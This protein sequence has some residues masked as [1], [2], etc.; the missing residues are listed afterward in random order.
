[1]I[2]VFVSV[3]GR[4]KR[5]END[6]GLRRY[7]AARQAAD[8]DR[9]RRRELR[10]TFF[11]RYVWRL[12]SRT[13]VQTGPAE[14]RLHRGL[15]CARRARG[16]KRAGGAWDGDVVSDDSDGERPPPR[17]QSTAEDP[18]RARLRKAAAAL[19]LS[20]APR[21]RLPCREAER[22]EVEAFILEALRAP[23]GDGRTLYVAGM[24]GTGKTATVREVVGALRTKA[25]AGE[26]P[27]FA[28]VEVDEPSGIL[29]LRR[30]S[31]YQ[32]I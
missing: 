10:D 5:R 25:D 3:G 29:A 28:F 6:L 24:P 17:R 7:V 31:R 11:C 9:E 19:Q 4:P 2:S 8:D 26:L 20:A 21:G 27:S 30:P 15:Q 12:G 22:S 16:A 14:R 32:H 23:G 13:L 18:A 1:M